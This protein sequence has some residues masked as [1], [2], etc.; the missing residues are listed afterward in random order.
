VRFW[1]EK[2]PIFKR[3]N[4]PFYMQTNFIKTFFVLLCVGMLSNCTKKLDIEPLTSV[5]ESQALKTSND[6]LAA[7]VG[8]YSDCGDLDFYGGG[9]Y[10]RA[11]LLADNDELNWS[12]TFQGLTQIYNK[13]MTVDNGAVNTTWQAAYTVINEANN[14]LSALNLVV[15]AEK[16]RVEGEAKFLRASAYFELVRLFAK[17]WNNGSPSTNDGVPLILTPTR[18]P[19]TDADKKPRAKVTEVYQQIIADLTDAEAKLKIKGSG[20]K[21]YYAQK[22]TASAMLA[23]V[24]LQKQDYTNAAAAANR[25]ISASF[26]GNP[27]Y[28]LNFAYADEFPFNNSQPT[29]NTIEDVFAIQVVKTSVGNDFQ[30]F[31]SS[32]GRAEIDIKDTHLNLYDP[33]DDRLNLFSTSGGATYTG[34]FDNQSGNIHI[35]RLAEMYLTRAEANFRLGTTV[36]ATPL[37]DINL[38]RSR[39]NL[40]ALTNATLNLA[41]ILNE[42][43]LE[44]AFEGALLHD[45]KRTQGSV[46]GLNWDSPKLVFPIPDREIKINSKLTQNDGY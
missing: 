26:G 38:I 15:S 40:P 21:Y 43:K 29:T 41:A 32:T 30:N 3:N 23:R 44:L 14:I 22:T 42:R 16:D 9:V 45:I 25:T 11:E 1:K 13:A 7:L 36:G 17:P 35:I 5:D 31:F 24:Y 4:K 10:V 37:S 20:D 39:V 8:T 18:A 33:G 46:G 27:V 19:I 28:D 12:G 2:N 6:V 34:K